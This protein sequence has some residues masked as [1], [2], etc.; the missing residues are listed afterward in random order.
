M[1]PPMSVVFI[2]GIP[3]SATGD[4]DTFKTKDQANEYAQ[5]STN[6]KRSQLLTFSIFVC[7]IIFYTMF[8][9]VI[10]YAICNINSLDLNPI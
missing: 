10:F 7:K 4:T 1:Y 8:Y 6:V 9:K 2:K 5:I 3:R